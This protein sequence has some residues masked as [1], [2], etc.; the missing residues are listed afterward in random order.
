MSNP[1]CRTDLVVIQRLNH[2]QCSVFN[3]FPCTFQMKSTKNPGP[4]RQNS[5]TS[6]MWEFYHRDK[7][8]NPCSVAAATLF[9][10]FSKLGPAARGLQTAENFL[11]RSLAAKTKRYSRPFVCSLR[12]LLLF[13]ERSLYN[14]LKR[15]GKLMSS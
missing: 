5:T 7:L 11:L 8:L 3:A 2:L 1:Q 10:K 14:G 13:S 12:L 9:G 15:R 6:Q 4:D